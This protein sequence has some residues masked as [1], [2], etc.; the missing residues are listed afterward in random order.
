MLYMLGRSGYGMA[1]LVA[2]LLVTTVGTIG[3]APAQ[4]PERRTLLTL[5]ALDDP[6]AVGG[7]PLE[8]RIGAGMLMEDAAHQMFMR[9]AE[10]GYRAISSIETHAQVTFQDHVYDCAIRLGSAQEVQ[11]WE[12]RTAGN[13]AVEAELSRWVTIGSQNCADTQRRVADATH[14]TVLGMTATSNGS[15]SSSFAEKYCRPGRDVHSMYEFQ[16]L[17]ALGDPLWPA[18]GLEFPKGFRESAPRCVEVSDGHA[19]DPATHRLT[20][21]VYRL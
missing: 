7:E 8:V 5:I 9:A 19:M 10:L 14:H 21:I 4:Y 1:A 2:G 11:A 18:I 20:G 12:A 3:C 13:P 17:T 15:G 6:R 16:R